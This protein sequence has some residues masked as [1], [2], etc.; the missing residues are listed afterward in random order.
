MLISIRVAGWLCKGQGQ[1]QDMGMS[2]HWLGNGFFYQS[3]GMMVSN[4]ATVPHLFQ[5]VL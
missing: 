1:V 3:V 2:W 4:Q 5:E